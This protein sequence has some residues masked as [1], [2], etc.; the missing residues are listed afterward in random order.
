MTIGKE[1]VMEGRRKRKAAVATVGAVIAAGVV[2]VFAGSGSAAEQAAPVNST[3]PTVSG[4]PR[5]GQV[6]TGTRG[7][8]NGNPTDYNYF[9]TRCGRNGG[10]CANISGATR[11]TYSPK[12][13]DVG[14]TLRFKVEAVNADGR[15]F[16]SSVPTAIVQRAAATPPAAPTGCAGNAPL[17]VG[18]ISL[19]DR[20]DIDAGN[21]TPGIVG[22]STQSVTLR[23]HVTCKG[24]AV[25]GALVYATAV[26]FNQ[27]TV[28]Q[29]VATGADG[30]AQLTMTQL[31]GFPAARQQ[32]L[33]VVFARARK[34]GENVNGGISTRRLVSFP[35]DLRR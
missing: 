17:Q 30:F 11:P 7:D 33:L 19:P 23:F 15:T 14:F 18:G 13:V 22:R 4:T 6:L 27:F 8:W 35:V 2:S 28:P 3:P 5:V 10:S 20:L 16:A 26:P 31:S 29:E 21:I 32:Q 1:H 25:Q 12:S 9:W 24:K 34:P